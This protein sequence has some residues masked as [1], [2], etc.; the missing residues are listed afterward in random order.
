MIKLKH[1]Q[2]TRKVTNIT[3]STKGVSHQFVTYSILC[4]NAVFEEGFIP[5]LTT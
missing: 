4:A 1:Q 2:Y 5:L 3:I